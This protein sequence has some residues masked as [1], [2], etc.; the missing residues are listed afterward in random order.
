[1]QRGLT[2]VVFRPYQPREALAISLTL[3]DVHLVSLRPEFEGMVVP[4]KVYGV[5][6]AGRPCIFIGDQE[7]EIARMLREGECGVTVPGSD[8]EAL[9]AAIVALRDNAA[10]CAAMGA[11]ARQMFE[12]HFDMPVALARWDEVLADVARG[13]P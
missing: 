9:T 3:P 12:T 1:M 8:G 10:R 2:N 7:G 6:A 11:S 4:S 13:A 5:M